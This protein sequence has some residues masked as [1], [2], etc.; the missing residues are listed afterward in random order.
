M[1]KFRTNDQNKKGGQLREWQLSL[2]GVKLQEIKSL[3]AIVFVPQLEE[4]ALNWN[5]LN[6]KLKTLILSRQRAVQYLK[7]RRWM[8]CR[9]VNLASAFGS[10]GW[11]RWPL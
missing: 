1:H 7:K 3:E 8:I 10:L 6:P 2:T 5:L 9:S 11:S 4:Q